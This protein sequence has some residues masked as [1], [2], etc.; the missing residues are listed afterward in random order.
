CTLFHGTSSAASRRSIC[1]GVW[2]PLTAITKRPRAATAARA[3]A[4]ISPAA[5]RA[6]ASPSDRISVCTL[7]PFALP[8]L[9]SP[10]HPSPRLPARSERLGSNGD[11]LPLRGRGDCATLSPL[12]RGQGEGRCLS[13]TSRSHHGIVPAAWRRHRVRFLRSPCAGLV[14]VHRRTRFEHR[15]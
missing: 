10:H 9:V 14:L 11:P 6:T 5:F 13:S 2:P 12:G 15:I 3:S 7:A 4:A 1:Q 8:Q